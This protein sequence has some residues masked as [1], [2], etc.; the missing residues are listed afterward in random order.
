MTQKDSSEQMPFVPRYQKPE[1]TGVSM[2]FDNTVSIYHVVEPE[3]SFESAMP[4]LGY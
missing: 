1:S 3:D 4:R 2:N